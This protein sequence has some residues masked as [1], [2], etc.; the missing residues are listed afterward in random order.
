MALGFAC[1]GVA[2][3]WMSE[4][5]GNMTQVALR[6]IGAAILT[7]IVFYKQISW[8]KIISSTP[9]TLF[10]LITIGFLGY[11]GMVYFITLGSLTTKLLNVAV[12]YSTVPFFVYLGGLFVWKR[13]IQ[14]KVILL[15]LI[16]IWGVGILTSGNIFPSISGFGRGELY[17]LASAIFEAIYFI[18]LKKLEGRLNSSE[19]AAASLLVGG[20]SAFILSII[21]G[22]S[23]S[24]AGLANWHVSVAL[25]FGI[26][27][28]IWVP[29]LTMFA[30]THINEVVA[31]QLFL[32]ENFF[33][34]IFGYLLYNEIVN[35]YQI[36]GAA[37]I[38]AS[39]YLMNQVE[40]T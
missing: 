33:A 25:S 37:V 15:L 1:M 14:L 19:I 10:I 21:L 5:F 29:L 27:Q 34:L 12:L 30:F 26:L 7:S 31:T 8:K 3:R 2:S 17:V 24:F 38:I 36:A 9:K 23:L 16:S 18:G 28:N 35:I 32:L 39:V 13:K 40:S 4:G 6:I 11:A 20:L 22:E